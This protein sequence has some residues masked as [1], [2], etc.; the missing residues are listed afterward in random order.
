[1]YGRKGDTNLFFS[2]NHQIIS[3]LVICCYYSV[4]FVDFQLLIAV[5]ARTLVATDAVSKE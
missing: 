5:R 4:N 2:Q 1:M 3:L